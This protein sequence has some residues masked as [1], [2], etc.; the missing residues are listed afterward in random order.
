MF[1]IVPACGTKTRAVSGKRPCAIEAA[2]E[3][4]S[5]DMLMSISPSF[6]SWSCTDWFSGKA[7]P[8]RQRFG[9]IAS[10]HAQSGAVWVA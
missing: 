4:G 1:P 2:V 6:R 10:Y 7:V 3:A 5:K 9:R 8:C